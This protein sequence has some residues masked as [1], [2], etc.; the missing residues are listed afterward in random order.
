MFIIYEISLLFLCIE[1]FQQSLHSSSQD[2]QLQSLM[3]SLPTNATPN[4]QT[5]NFVITQ[6]SAIRNS[7]LNP[8]IGNESTEQIKSAFKPVKPRLSSIIPI[9]T[10]LPNVLNN[11]LSMHISSVASNNSLRSLPDSYYVSSY[12]PY[13][14]ANST[15]LENAN[16]EAKS[17]TWLTEYERTLK[18]NE[19]NFRMAYKYVAD[20]TG[21]GNWLKNQLIILFSY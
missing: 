2:S 3:Y 20:E 9:P 21:Q 16:N 1:C 4:H 18:K 14:Q 11:N 5:S 10:T 15:K 17:S 13:N 12:E 6:S 8:T 7:Y 19:S